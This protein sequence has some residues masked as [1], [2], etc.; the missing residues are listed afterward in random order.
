MPEPTDNGLTEFQADVTRLFFALPES[1]G[2]LFA[3]AGALLAQGLT[4]RPTEDLDF[5]GAAGRASIRSASD[6]LR[7]ATEARGWTIEV[8][9]DFDTFCRMRIAATSDLVVDLAI[10]SAPLREP[11]ITVVGPSFDTGPGI[12]PRLPRRQHAPTATSE[13]PRTCSSSRDA[14]SSTEV[15]HRVGGRAQP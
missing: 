14:A 4:H 3:G 7:R 9:R 13:R 1:T 10:D 12:P 5:F 2:F 6:A 15:L 11:R 8:V